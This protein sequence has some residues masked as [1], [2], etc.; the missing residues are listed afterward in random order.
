[1]SEQWECPACGKLYPTVPDECECGARVYL[2][3]PHSGTHRVK[4]RKMAILLALFFGW[5]GAHRFYLGQP[6]RGMIFVLFFWTL[7]PCL[8]GWIDM[9][10][11]IFSPIA[12]QAKYNRL[13][14]PSIQEKRFENR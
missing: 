3:T 6:L 7:I 14:A 10:E 2:Q 5:I 11:Y 12:F 13:V 8:Y 1:M 4:S 9:M